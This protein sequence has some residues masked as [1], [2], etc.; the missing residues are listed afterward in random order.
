MKYVLTVSPR[1]HD[2]IS[3]C[4]NSI[5]ILKWLQIEG[6]DIIEKQLTDE[7][8][9]VNLPRSD[10]TSRHLFRCVIFALGQLSTVGPSVSS[11]K[12][13]SLYLFRAS[14]ETNI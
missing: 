9:E 6:T 8:T 11:T 13:L 5:A 7:G 3:P 12:V 14:V 10:Q 1:V 2:L 4:M